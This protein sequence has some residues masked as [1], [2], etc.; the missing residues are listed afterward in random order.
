MPP[1]QRY[2]R[3]AVT[4]IINGVAGLVVVPFACS[5]AAILFGLWGRGRVARKP[6]LKGR[7]LATAGVWLGAVG[8]IVAAAATIASG[9][10]SWNVFSP[11]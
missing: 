11:D 7:G 3:V 5:L 4:A 2:S 9:G 6:E 8:L 10:W 1:E